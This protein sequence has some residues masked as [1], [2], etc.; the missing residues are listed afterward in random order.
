MKF[1]NYL[2]IGFTLVGLTHCNSGSSSHNISAS[3]QI[4]AKVSGLDSGQSV[5][6][7]MYADRFTSVKSSQTIT[8]NTSSAFSTKVDKYDDIVVT[9]A[10]QPTNQACTVN[11]AFSK[12]VSQ[13]TL[14]NVIC[15][16]TMHMISGTVTGLAADKT[17]TVA[18]NRDY[19]TTIS[20]NGNF[21]FDADFADA[22]K[23]AVTIATPPQ[24]QYCTLTNNSGTITS[25]VTDVT[26]T[27]TNAHQLFT[28]YGKL[29]K[30]DFGG[31]EVADAR[32]ENYVD[33]NN[34]DLS[35]SG[36]LVA[37]MST[38]SSDEIRDF[39]TTYSLDTTR[40]IYTENLD[41]YGDMR[42]IGV[43]DK[44]ADD[45]TDLL[46]GSVDDIPNINYPWSGSDSS[47]AVSDNCNNWSSASSS[48]KSNNMKN[49]GKDSTWLSYSTTCDQSYFISCLCINN[50]ADTYSLGGTVTGL[51][52]GE[53]ITLLLENEE[54]T[55]EVSADGSF[56]FETE[57]EED[58]MYEVSIS[59]D[60]ADQTCTI[61]NE[62][63]TIT[64]ANVSDIEI[65]CTTD[66]EE[67]TSYTVGGTVS[68]LSGELIL[69]LNSGAD[70]LEVSADGSFTFAMELE[71]DDDYDISISDDPVDQT[72]TIENGSGT[73]TSSNVSTIEITCA[74]D[75]PFTVG[76]SVSGY[77]S[78]QHL[79]LDLFYNNG[80]DFEMA[81]I[82]ANGSFTFSTELSLGDSYE[83][84]ISGDPCGLTCAITN[85]SGENI[86]GDVN[87]VTVTCTSGGFAC[88]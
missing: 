62:S 48:V 4:S 8:T 84:M 55:L 53:T 40:K 10:T 73:I 64:N 43:Y 32:C 35:C 6:L 85:A 30:G 15:S 17:F 66:E 70:T 72:C 46:D 16:S 71:A 44:L 61:T 67:V 69:I 45:F 47:G 18:A 60:P 22:A 39:P 29:Y 24:G 74:E 59:D 81:E 34:F 7:N 68:G 51:E 86:S 65:T 21:T 11:E 28:A 50:D 83:V 79:F 33:T 75:P 2:L 42:A 80:E 77:S 58:D 31:R 3:I 9:V 49:S 36:G 88:P 23:Y 82:T 5:T 27:C 41:H 19:I 63:G 56:T 87:N 14:F 76:G 52:E 78:P 54:E 12:N 26:I 13:D 57:L 1:F 38:S 25:D 37:F 20:G